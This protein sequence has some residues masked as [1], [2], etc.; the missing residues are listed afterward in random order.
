MLSRE[1]L[2]AGAQVRRSARRR[3]TVS[4]SLRDGRLVV[5]VPSTLT[6]A[7]ERAW[8]G[9]MADRVLSSRARTRPSD[10]ALLERALVL[11]RLHLAG[12]AVPA[13]VVWTDD[14]HTRWGSTTPLDGSIRLSTRLRGLPA[15]VVDHVLLHELVHLLEPGHGPRFRALLDPTPR[16]EQARGYL[17]GYLAGSDDTSAEDGSGGGLDDD[18][19]AS[20]Q[21]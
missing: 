13:S 2:V 8:V 16:A 12:A 3:R 15:W 6:R 14:Q 5:D 1:A 9:K 11:S 18:G 19:F 17:E 10:G 7:Q 20:Q 21:G 4:A